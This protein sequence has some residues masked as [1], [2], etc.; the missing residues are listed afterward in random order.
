MR[1]PLAAIERSLGFLNAADLPLVQVQVPIYRF[2][3]E[4]RSA[5]PGALGQFLD[6]FL[7]AGSMRTLTVVEDMSSCAVVID[8]VHK[9]VLQHLGA[10]TWLF[11]S[12][13]IAEA[14]TWPPSFS[15]MNSMP[16]LSK[17]RLSESKPQTVVA[18]AST[19]RAVD[20][21][22]RDQES[23]WG[24]FFSCPPLEVVSA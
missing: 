2:S 8:C 22:K 5:P 6:R 16:A 19:F 15:S 18:R 14:H 7:M 24:R 1:N 20:G 11:S 17:A 12:G 4:E 23:L 21:C 13:A 9:R 10:F 3:G